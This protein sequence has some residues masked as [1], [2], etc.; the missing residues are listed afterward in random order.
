M[1]DGLIFWLLC[2]L[3]GRILVA[4]VS[5]GKYTTSLPDEL[6]DP[7]SRWDTKRQPDGRIAVSYETVCLI[8]F[9]FWVVLLFLI[10]LG[11]WTGAYDLVTPLRGWLFGVGE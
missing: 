8:G 11:F 7:F 2:F 1:F 5:F 6:S 9:M 3:P 10:G 4:I